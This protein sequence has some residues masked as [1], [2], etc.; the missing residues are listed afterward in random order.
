MAYIC[1]LTILR[2]VALSPLQPSEQQFQWLN[3]PFSNTIHFK[4]LGTNLSGPDALS[5]LIPLS[6]FIAMACSELYQS[7]TT[8]PLPCHQTWP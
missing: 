7:H 4:N 6:C 2:T 3:N 8:N 5:S 1:L